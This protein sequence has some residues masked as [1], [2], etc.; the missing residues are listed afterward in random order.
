[1]FDPSGI[2]LIGGEGAD[3]F[4]GGE[5]GGSRVVIVITDIR[6]RSG[7]DSIIQK[8]GEEGDNRGR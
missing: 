5:P 2:G 4:N 8:G 1:M 7:V 6:G 3:T